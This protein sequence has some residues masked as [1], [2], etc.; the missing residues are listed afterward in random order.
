MKQSFINPKV[1][2]V[3]TVTYYPEFPYEKDE[4]LFNDLLTLLESVGLDRKNPFKDYIKA[5]GVAL[6]KPNWVLDF[7]L[8]GKGLDCLLTH[9]SLIKYLID[10]L[11]IAMNGS[12]TI[13]IGD[14]P[15]QNCDFENI[16]RYFKLDDL[17]IKMK[18]QHPGIDIKIEDWRLTKLV[19]L[20]KIGKRQFIKS[21][22]FQ[23]INFEEVNKYFKLI[24]LG[25]ESFLEDIAD[26][27]NRFRVTNYKPSLILK[28]HNKGK[29][30]YLIN[31]RIFDVDLVI[32]FA[33]MKTHI[34]AGLTGALKNLVGING[35]KEFLPHHIKGS[36][37]EGGDNYL[38]PNWFRRKFEDFEDWFWEHVDERSIFE[39]NIYRIVA[40]MLWIFSKFSVREE[41]SAGSWRGND[42]I[43]RTILDLNHIAYFNEF[44]TRPILNIV[45][46]IISGEGEGPLA[47]EPKLTGLLIAG[48]NPAYVD[49]VI[50]KLM[51]YTVARIPAVYNAIYHRKSKFYAG[52]LRE[53]KIDWVENGVKQ[54]LAFENLPNLQFKKPYY[55]R[56]A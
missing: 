11:A 8:S 12:G 44:K 45:D 52:D 55:W 9:I 20:L 56:G 28:H 41:V 46:G 14:A 18:N 27:S 13:I 49:A 4:I 23:S 38:M 10:L 26:F 37:F 17:I 3:K 48:W 21:Q 32:N 43:W 47:P 40:K 31:K 6:I 1:S 36:Y 2:I 5:N 42:T 35:H 54:I 50:A 19:R 29:H 15:L 30:E 7:N 24:D 33:K 22:D 39:N 34:K 16:K 51:G 53:T 25:S